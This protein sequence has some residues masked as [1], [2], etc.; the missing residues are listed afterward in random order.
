[1]AAVFHGVDLDLNNVAS[2]DYR[3]LRR[4]PWSMLAQW[5]RHIPVA[6]LAKPLILVRT[7]VA[8]SGGALVARVSWAAGSMA[9]SVD[10]MIV[11]V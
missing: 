11:R 2:H 10:A 9:R 4:L 1:M 3:P 7:S 5:S 6:T 8:E